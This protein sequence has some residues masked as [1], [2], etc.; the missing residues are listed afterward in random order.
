MRDI[1][2]HYHIEKELANRLRT[3][4]KE[5]RRHLYRTVYN[6]LEERVP[7]HPALTRQK[8]RDLQHKH[9]L[10]QLS[11]LTEYFSPD[12]VFLEL[13]AG[14][15]A[16]SF[17]LCKHFKKVYAID[18]SEE[19]IKGKALPANFAF[20]PTDGTSVDVT[21]ETVNIAYSNQVMEH[22]HPEDA[23]V[24]LQAIYD[25]LVPGGTYLCITPHRFMGPSDI[26]KYF[27]NVA[28][29]LHLKEY[30]HRELHRLFRSL[31]FRRIRSVVQV[32]HIRFS[33]STYWA[34]VLELVIGPLHHTLRRRIS[35]MIIVRNI[36][37]AALK[38]TK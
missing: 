9:V 12:H 10:N 37:T 6:E 26:S 13:G 21:P 19:R 11:L 27:D 4:P 8:N 31:G 28:T 34:I 1:I 18:V 35:R 3:A 2:E 16:T 22:I 30:T 20:L 25:S 17:A 15:C 24:Q 36:L 33:I 38:A 32:R 23:I 5:E 29:G 14:D 7:H